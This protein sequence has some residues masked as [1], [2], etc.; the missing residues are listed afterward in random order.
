M[1]KISDAALAAYEPVRERRQQHLAKLTEE[2]K[3]RAERHF[4]R[5][6]GE[7][8]DAVLEDGAIIFTI[9]GK[10]RLA[11]V[12]NLQSDRRMVGAGWSYLERCAGCKKEQGVVFVRT[13]ADL[14][15]VIVDGAPEW[16]CRHCNGT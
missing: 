2:R 6:F 14:G 9:D 5:V 15:A 13:L 8:Q 7:K 1:S 10:H 16:E 3:A 4:E 11:Y 12:G